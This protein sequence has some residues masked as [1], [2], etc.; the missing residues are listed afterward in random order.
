MQGMYFC[1]SVFLY[2]CMS[3]CLYVC[4]YGCHKKYSKKKQFVL[5]T[6]AHTHT[7]VHTIH[8]YIYNTYNIFTELGHAVMACQ[9]KTVNLNIRRCVT[10]CLSTVP[11]NLVDA[12]WAKNVISS[13]P[14]CVQ[15]QSPNL[16]VLT[17][18]AIWG[19]S[20]TASETWERRR[21][22]TTRG[23]ITKMIRNIK[24]SCRRTEQKTLIPNLPQTILF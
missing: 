16:S 14:R 21:Y 17:T 4:M 2:V 10:S 8:I 1:I 24:K 6:H 13:I 9:V 7:H 11:N 3:A 15:H 18:S 20:K 22:E 23:S 19:M 5:K 12:T